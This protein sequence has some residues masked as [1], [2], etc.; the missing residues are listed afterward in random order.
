MREV[1]PC[2]TLHGVRHSVSAAVFHD[3]NSEDRPSAARRRAVTHYEPL[4]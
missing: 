1:I 2:E 4:R 3:L